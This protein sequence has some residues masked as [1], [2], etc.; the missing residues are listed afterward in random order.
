MRFA[1][2]ALALNIAFGIPQAYAA[3]VE[4]AVGLGLTFFSGNESTHLS[5]D[6]SPHVSFSANILQKRINWV[7]HFEF[8]FMTGGKNFGGTMGT[9]TG[10]FGTYSLGMRVNLAKESMQPYF[11]LGPTVGMFAATVSS[12]PGTESKNQTAFKYGYM[13]GVGFDWLKTAR[14]GEG[15]GWGMGFNYFS[16]FKSPSVFEFS[17]A[18]L[19]IQ[20]V[21]FEFRYLLQ[22]SK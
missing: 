2:I 5:P 11:E 12:P 18:A 8:G 22:P 9:Y 14:R 16:Y 7:N 4:K 10:Y 20:G 17:G 6:L 3:R 19:A 21:K 13:L 15:T 1:W